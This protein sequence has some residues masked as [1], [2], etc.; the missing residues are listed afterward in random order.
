MSA[1]EKNETYLVLFELSVSGLYFTSFSSAS[2]CG[3]FQ[4]AG[5]HWSSLNVLCG[6]LLNSIVSV[7]LIFWFFFA[8]L[9]FLFI[10]FGVFKPTV[11]V[12]TLVEVS[13]GEIKTVIC[14]YRRCKFIIYSACLTETL[15]TI[16][17]LCTV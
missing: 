11:E 15:L 9:L 3:V 5:R 1:Y 17:S 10:L 12:I 7:C 14:R 8:E 16:P 13:L 2:Y 6:C 4:I